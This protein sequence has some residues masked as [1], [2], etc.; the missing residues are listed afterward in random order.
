MNKHTKR[1]ARKPVGKIRYQSTGK[2]L[3]S[4]AGIIPAMRFLNR[5]GFDSLCQQ[6]LDLQRG[7]NAIYNMTDSVYLSVIG[8]IAGA[9]SLLKVVTVWSDEVLREVGGWV[10]VPDDST[11]GRIFRLAQLRHVVQLE[12]VTHK[13]RHRV[14]ERAYKSSALQLGDFYHSWVD[15]DGRGNFEKEQ[16]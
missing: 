11:L 7:S 6:K 14:W 16:S 2:R 12:D 3:T 4:Q 1:I 8:L 5:L 10:S 13:M 15:V 9:T